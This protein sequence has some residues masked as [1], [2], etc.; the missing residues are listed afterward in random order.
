MIDA[1]LVDTIYRVRPARDSWGEIIALTL[2]ELR[3]RITYKVR[4]VLNFKGEE[5]LSDRSV[6]LQEMDIHPD[7]RIRIGGLSGVDWPIKRIDKPKDFT[8]NVVEVFI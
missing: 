6:L 7:D 2:T 1:Y 3:G 8:W 4:K 5:V